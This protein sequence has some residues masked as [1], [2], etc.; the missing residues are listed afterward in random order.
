MIFPGIILL[1][2]IRRRKRERELEELREFNKKLKN[3]HNEY[4]KQYSLTKE[5]N[6]VVRKISISN[7][8]TKHYEDFYKF[9][10]KSYQ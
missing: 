4:N 10:S 7:Y 6:D 5:V 3:K 2:V 1:P 9:L 8:S